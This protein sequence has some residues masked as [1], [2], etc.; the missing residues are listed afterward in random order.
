M[1][2]LVIPVFWPGALKFA[3]EK[4]LPK[5]IL[6][7]SDRDRGNPALLEAKAVFPH[8]PSSRLETG[9][10]HCLSSFQLSGFLVFSS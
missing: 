2:T 7:M 3:G 4:W 6:L 9:S 1:H 5:V 8:L 10:E